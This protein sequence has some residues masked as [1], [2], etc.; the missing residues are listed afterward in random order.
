MGTQQ[1]WEEEGGGVGCKVVEYAWVGQKRKA[2]NSKNTGGIGFLV[3]EFLCD[4]I[5]VIEDTTY[6]E[7]IW[8]RVPG[9]RAAK[10]FFLD[11]FTCPSRV[12]QYGKQR[13]RRSSER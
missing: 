11:T 2:Q 8:I 1:S 6:D 5:E 4:T 9:E 7:N 3:K 12:K 13:Y 10:Y